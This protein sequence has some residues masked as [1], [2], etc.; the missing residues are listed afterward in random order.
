MQRVINTRASL[1][2]TPKTPEPFENLHTQEEQL[3]L[4]LVVPEKKGKVKKPER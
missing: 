1:M 3:E 4:P 2:S